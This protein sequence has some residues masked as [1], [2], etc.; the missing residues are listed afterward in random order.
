MLDCRT[1]Q[2]WDKAH[3]RALKV[4]QN[5][6]RKANKLDDIYHCPTYYSG[7]NLR[8]IRRN[9]RYQGSTPAEINHASNTAYFGRGNNW[10]VMKLINEMMKRQK[11]KRN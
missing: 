3:H 5:N 1:K 10:T 2:K 6:P 4:M 9:M 7:Y 11:N 8:S